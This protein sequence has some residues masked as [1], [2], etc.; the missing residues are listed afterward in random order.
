MLAKEKITIVGAGLTGSL[1]GIYLAK[2]KWPLH[3][4]EKRPSYRSGRMA[5]G[6]SIN[7]AISSRGLLALEQVNLKEKI[8]QKCVKM[9]ARA[10]HQEDGRIVD[11]PY[12]RNENENLYSLSRNDLN[13][14]LLNELE[15]FPNVQIDYEKEITKM[16]F[17]NGVVLGTDGSSGSLRLNMPNVEEKRENLEHFYM[18]LTMPIGHPF[19]KERL[20][21]WPRKDFM[22]IALPN[23]Q[24]DFTCTLFMPEKLCKEIRYNFDSFFKEHFFDAYQWMPQL[25]DDFEKNPM[26]PLSTLYCSPWYQDD[27][28]LLLGDAAHAIVP[29]YGQGMNCC[30]EDCRIFHELLSK[31][32]DWG[33]LFQEF[34]ISR[35]KNADAIAQMAIENYL[36]MRSHTA[37][38]L[39]HFI[40]ITENALSST[41]PNQYASGYHMVTFS[42]YSEYHKIQKAALEQRNIL[43]S[44]CTALRYSEYQKSQEFKMDE[45]QGLLKQMGQYSIV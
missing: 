20:H 30:F 5:A 10:I 14:M 34:Y 40:K 1:L 44:F 16:D 25:K 39:F 2:E 38:E 37:D 28:A 43:R 21:I 3:I 9:Q 45:L 18:E 32:N 19:N 26:S 33:S 27:K 41:F 29:F 11:M 4:F 35:K 15:S 31:H 8:L 22:L 12:G 17:S 23:I 7:L 42:P 6:K 13:E 36:E 24:G